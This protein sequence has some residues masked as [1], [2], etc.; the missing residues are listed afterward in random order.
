MPFQ[1]YAHR[2]SRT[3][4]AH[5]GGTPAP[6]ASKEELESLEKS[7][8]RLYRVVDAIHTQTGWRT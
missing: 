6:S 3:L 7:L 4:P 1:E 8:H 5:C 2:G